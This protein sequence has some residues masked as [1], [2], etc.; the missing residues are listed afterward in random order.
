ML[1]AYFAY[2]QGRPFNREVGVSL[3]Q[4][5]RW[6]AAEERG[7]QR[8]PNPTYLDLRLEKE[9]KLWGRTRLKLLIDVWNTFNA[10]YNNWVAE[11]N[12]ASDAYLAPGGY[13]LPRRAQLGIRFVF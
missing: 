1:S 3:D 5:R 11:T 12:A 10:D 6:I 9:F 13:V 2:D 4:G 8:Y 7:S